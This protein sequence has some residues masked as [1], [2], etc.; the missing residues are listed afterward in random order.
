MAKKK[1]QNKTQ[2][3]KQYMEE[4]PDAGPKKVAEALSKAGIKVSAQYVSTIKSNH[5]RRQ[6]SLGKLEDCD[7]PLSSI[8]AAKRLVEQVG[9]V[10]E[11]R[12]ALEALT[13][14]R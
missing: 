3:I 2:A 7:I 5:K 1:S 8:L 6:P 10:D 12:A 4:H 13:L 9:G 14:L 11:A